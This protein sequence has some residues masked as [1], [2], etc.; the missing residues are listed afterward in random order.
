MDA[1][2]LLAALWGLIDENTPNSLITLDQIYA[3]GLNTGK[4]RNFLGHRPIIS[5]DPLKFAPTYS[6]I[7]YGEVDVRRRYI[8]SA[9]HA[10]FQK[11]ELGGGEFQSVGIWAPNRPG[12]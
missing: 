2:H 11:G 7:T 3:V 5:T 4:D 9:L 8:G 1:S 10:L 12:K 6:W